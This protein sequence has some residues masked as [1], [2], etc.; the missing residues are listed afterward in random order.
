MYEGDKTLNL[1]FRD[2]LLACLDNW[3]SSHPNI[4]RIFFFVKVILNEQGFDE[5][6][7]G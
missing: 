5:Y 1:M 6:L 2:N 4:G 7:Q 3:K